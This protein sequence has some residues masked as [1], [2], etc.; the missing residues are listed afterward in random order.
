MFKLLL[1]TQGSKRIKNTTLKP[2]SHF[3]NA[4]AITADLYC[5]DDHSHAS[6]A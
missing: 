6:L 1:C 2:Y 3:V 4:I 5:Y